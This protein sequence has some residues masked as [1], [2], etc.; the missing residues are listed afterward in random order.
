MWREPEEQFLPVLEE[1]GSG[2]VQFSPHGKGFLTGAIDKD[3]QFGDK[4]FRNTVPR[5]S[6]E[7]RAAN[8]ALVDTFTRIA[9][10]KQ[11]PTAQLA[12]GWVLAQKPWIVP[13]PGTTKRQRLEENIGAADVVLTADEL[14]AIQQTVAGIEIKGERYS[15]VNQARIDR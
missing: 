13:V 2:F 12:L 9:A 1:L 11:V 10:Q 15:A 8:Q 14:T 6:A 5:F 7:N 4:D 3:T